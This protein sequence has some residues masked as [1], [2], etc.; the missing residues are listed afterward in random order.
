M[1]MISSL[2]LSVLMISNVHAAAGGAFGTVPA[3]KLLPLQSLR[4]LNASKVPPELKER[5]LVLN[6]RMIQYLKAE[7]PNSPL[8]DYANWSASTGSGDIPDVMVIPE[9]YDPDGYTKALDFALTNRVVLSKA[10]EYETGTF[11]CAED[12][13]ICLASYKD[14]TKYPFCGSLMMFC[15]I[16]QLIPE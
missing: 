12:Y 6:A 9:G 4:E 10:G 15:L 1:R 11:K 3:A 16:K 5:I 7:N 2:L 13:E 8:P 14:K